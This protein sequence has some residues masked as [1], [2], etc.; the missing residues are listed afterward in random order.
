MKQ[1]K[2]ASST[3]DEKELKGQIWQKPHNY[4]RIDYMEQSNEK[5]PSERISDV[6]NG[7]KKRVKRAGTKRKS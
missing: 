6:C 3:W 7:K 4:I 5:K 2:L 1:Y